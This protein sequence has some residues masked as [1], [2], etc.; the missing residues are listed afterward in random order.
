MNIVSKNLN[1]RVREEDI[2]GLNL[3]ELHQLEKIIQA[4]L[5]RVLETKVRMH[6]I[7]T[8]SGRDS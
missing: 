3:E 2:Q 7:S 4:G 5:N 8:L 1:R 6:L